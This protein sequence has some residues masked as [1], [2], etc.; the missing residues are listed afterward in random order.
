M[1][2]FTLHSDL[3]TNTKIILQISVTLAALTHAVI[4]A[5]KTYLKTFHPQLVGLQL[6]VEDPVLL[7]KALDPLLK[8]L[9]GDG[10]W[11]LEAVPVRLEVTDTI[12]ATAVTL[13]GRVSHGGGVWCLVWRKAGS[14]I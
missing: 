11:G 1:L 9:P 12:H 5:V 2:N 7:L 14:D 3:N 8:L 13:T 10:A 6:H 4:D